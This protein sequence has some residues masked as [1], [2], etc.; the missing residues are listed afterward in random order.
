MLVNNQQFGN[1]K[2]RNEFHEFWSSRNCD[3]LNSEYNEN[4]NNTT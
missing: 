1:I 4:G 3:F 2:D